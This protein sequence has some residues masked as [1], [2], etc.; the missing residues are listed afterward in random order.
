MKYIKIYMKYI[1]VKV[2]YLYESFGLYAL[3]SVGKLY[4][5]FPVNL[6]KCR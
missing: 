1:Y 4:W 6:I 2:I 5:E 3:I